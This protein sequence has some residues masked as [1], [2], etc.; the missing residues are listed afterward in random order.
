MSQFLAA[1]AAALAVG[2]LFPRPSGPEGITWFVAIALAAIATFLGSKPVASRGLVLAALLDMRVAFPAHPPSRLAVVRRASC[3]AA[4]EAL[5]SQNLDLADSADNRADRIALMAGVGALRSVPRNEAQL[6]LEIGDASIT[7]RVIE[8]DFLGYEQ[9]VPSESTARRLLRTALRVSVVA[10]LVATIALSAAH[11]PPNKRAQER[12]NG[13]TVPEVPVTRPAPANVPPATTRSGDST[14]PLGPTATTAPANTSQSPEPALADGDSSSLPHALPGPSDSRLL[15]T[16]AAQLPASGEAD[17]ASAPSGSTD[18]VSFDTTS[19]NPLATI[20]ATVPAAERPAILAAGLVPRLDSPMLPQQPGTIAV[21]MVVAPS[22]SSADV[23]T[24][25]VDS[26]TG[27]TD[28]GTSDTT[29]AANAQGAASDSGE[30]IARAV[31]AADSA[32]PDPTT[33]DA[34]SGATAESGSAPSDATADDAAPANTASS[35]ITMSDQRVGPLA[36]GA[37]GLAADRSDG[38]H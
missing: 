15:V 13:T 19:P 28:T 8:G 22:N 31:G 36:P 21:A 17:V 5:L 35:G 3:A 25:A 10:S 24:R 32:A 7:R 9:L 29:D 11:T 38:T 12:A 14:P 4:L 30:T 23:A 16:A 20:R 37:S 34:S 27:T 1:A 33:G 6:V 26:D 2:L 18:V